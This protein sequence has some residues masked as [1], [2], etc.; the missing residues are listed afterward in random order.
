MFKRRFMVSTLM[1]VLLVFA[2]IVAN[3][4]EG[5]PGIASEGE[6]DVEEKA[7]NE[8]DEAD[9][10]TFTGIGEGYGGD[11][12]VEVVMEGEKIK[13]VK[14]VSNDET[15]DIAGDAI[16]QLPQKIVEEQDYEVDSV[17]GATRTSEAIKEAVKSAVEKSED[18]ESSSAES[19]D[20][21]TEEVLKGTGEGY[22]GDVEV[23]VVMEG[24]KIKEVKVVSNDETPDIAGDAIEQ[25]PQKI[26]EEQDYEVDSVSG[27][28]RTSEAIKE[29]VQDALENG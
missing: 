24:E 16:E 13:E 15:P 2:F 7:Q 22:G 21:K 9:G 25:L 4:I 1:V 14:V 10:K 28:T 19:A 27:A 5:L 26:V 29:A 3:N 18:K 20:D 17:S 23:E 12:E 11:V 6:E 8:T